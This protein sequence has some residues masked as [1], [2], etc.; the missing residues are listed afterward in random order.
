MAL[1]VA[2]IHLTDPQKKVQG[3]FGLSCDSFLNGLVAGDFLTTFLLGLGTDRG[4]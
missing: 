4:P 2:S 1:E 3:G